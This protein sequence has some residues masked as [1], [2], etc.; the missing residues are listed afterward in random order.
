MDFFKN[1]FFKNGFFKNRFLQKDFLKNVFFQKSNGEKN[2]CSKMWFL[3]KRP[4][5]PL[6]ELQKKRYLEFVASGRPLATNYNKYILNIYIS[7]PA[8]GGNNF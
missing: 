2:I 8:G 4:A 7:A 3:R 6:P 1:G 5:F